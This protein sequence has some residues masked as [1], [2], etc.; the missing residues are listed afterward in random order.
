MADSHDRSNRVLF[1]RASLHPTTQHQQFPPQSSQYQMSKNN[2]NIDYPLEDSLNQQLKSQFLDD[3]FYKV[4]NTAFSFDNS[5][6]DHSGHRFSTNK[7][8]Y[9]LSNPGISSLSRP[10][11]PQQDNNLHY[12]P[13]NPKFSSDNTRHQQQNSHYHQS[14]SSQFAN[15][16]LGLAGQFNLPTNAG[17]R[18]PRQ[19]NSLGRIT[20]PPAISTSTVFSYTLAGPGLAAMFTPPPSFQNNDITPTFEETTPTNVTVIRG[21]MAE[22][23]CAVQNLGTKSVSVVTCLSCCASTSPSSL[24]FV[25]QFSGSDWIFRTFL[26]CNRLKRYSL[27]GLHVLHKFFF[28]HGGC[29]SFHQNMKREL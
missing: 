2:N 1:R 21:R 10:H 12:L 23:K 16:N 9:K 19:V 25:L 4:P 6:H 5:L 17:K 8:L 24:L 11:I 14:A 26:Q 28:K 20:P 3:K 27:S 13:A 18:A 29:I 22:L 7:T 15:S